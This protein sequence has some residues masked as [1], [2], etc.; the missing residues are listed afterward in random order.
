MKSFKKLIALV[1]LTLATSKTASGAPIPEQ[2]L[3]LTG[4]AINTDPAFQILDENL[5]APSTPPLRRL[6]SIT[7]I[8]N[9]D[10]AGILKP[11]LTSAQGVT[12]GVNKGVE[13]G[14]GNIDHGLHSVG[15]AASSITSGAADI[16]GGTLEGAGNTVAAVPKALYSI[17]SNL[18]HSKGLLGN[19]ASLLK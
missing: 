10:L 11:V 13:A 5:S 15:S 9:R 2:A 3:D 1:A 18:D 16:T 6:R 7:N 12:E 19:I 8:R 4:Q 17:L 14:A